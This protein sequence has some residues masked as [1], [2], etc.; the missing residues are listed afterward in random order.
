MALRNSVV[1]TI[2]NVVYLIYTMDD[3]D[4]VS[5]CRRKLFNWLHVLEFVNDQHQLVVINWIIHSKP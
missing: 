4:R 5:F 2:S 1:G 3:A